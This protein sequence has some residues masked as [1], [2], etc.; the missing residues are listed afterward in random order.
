MSANMAYGQVKLEPGEG[1]Y[2]DPD[3]IRP[4]PGNYEL[5]QHS[6]DDECSGSKQATTLDTT[7]ED[8]SR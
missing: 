8:S 4:G 6:I 7:A 2:E 5:A 1:E 3:K